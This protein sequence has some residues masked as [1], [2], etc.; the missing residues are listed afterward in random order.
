MGPHGKILPR[1]AP[2]PVPV[3]ASITLADGLAVIEGR[4]VSRIGWTAIN[5]PIQAPLRTVAVPAPVKSISRAT[6]AI[7]ITRFA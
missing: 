6:H 2:A 3:V 5:F 7:P 1:V 4:G